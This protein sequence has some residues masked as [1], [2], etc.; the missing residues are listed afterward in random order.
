MNGLVDAGFIVL[1]GPLAAG[2]TILLIVVA[3]DEAT[4]RSRLSADPW[5]PVGLLKV[6]TVQ[7]WTV[8][9]D[10]RSRDAALRQR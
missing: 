2:E 10:G 7:P 5:A 6:A 4:I 8:L 9:L 1:G 3:E